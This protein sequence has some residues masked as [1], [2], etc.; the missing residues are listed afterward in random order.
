MTESMTVRRAL[1]QSGLVPIDAHVLLAH[2]LERGR[3]WL[4]AHADD[5]LPAEQV[6][7]FLALACRRRDGEPIA[8]LTG[9]REFWGMPLTVS[10]AVLIPRPETE[11]LVEVALTL[12]PADRA[13][14]VLDLGTGSGAVALALARELPRATIVATDVSAAALEVARTNARRLGV[15]NVTWLASDWYA[16]VG[17][18]ER[19]DVIVSNPP[20]V[21]ADD[22]HMAAGD[23]RYEPV[24]ALTAGADALLALRRVI[25]GATPFLA[26]GGSV[27]VEHGYDQA[28]TV[29]SLFGD[30]GF[31]E[32]RTTRDI[33]GVPRVTSGRHAPTS[34]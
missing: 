33:A 32:I 28:E 8:Y 27:A 3:A 21:D 5:A 31:T 23:L 11:T 22:P 6:A 1:V 14:R 24:G 20:Y 2:V 10:P 25:V 7:A 9:V 16:G 4:V 18:A 12:L 17:L 19:F 26:P 13:I 34:S 15:G 29:R 30:A